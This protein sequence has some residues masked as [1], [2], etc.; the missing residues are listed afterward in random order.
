MALSTDHVVAAATTNAAK[1]ENAGTP[2]ITQPILLK[3]FL[4]LVLKKLRLITF[5]VIVLSEQ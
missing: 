4:L 3:L 5:K 1:T 2:S